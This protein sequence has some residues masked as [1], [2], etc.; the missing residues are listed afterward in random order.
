[1]LHTHRQLGFP[2]LGVLLDNAG[3]ESG[4]W[5]FVADRCQARRVKG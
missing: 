5:S 3:T 4:L 2:F 1:M